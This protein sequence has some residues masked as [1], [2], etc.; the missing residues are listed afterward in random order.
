MI[1]QIRKIPEPNPEYITKCDEC[2]HFKIVL[3]DEKY[4]C[5]KNWHGRDLKHNVHGVYVIPDWCPLEDYNDS[6]KK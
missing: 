6:I 1:K 3:Q 2:V 4:Y 5:D